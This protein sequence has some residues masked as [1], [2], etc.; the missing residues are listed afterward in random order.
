MTLMDAMRV[1]NEPNMQARLD[2][3]K[4]YTDGFY[5]WDVRQQQWTVML[6]NLLV[7]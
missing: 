7:E 3:Q 1:I 6:N 2:M 5:S 4:S